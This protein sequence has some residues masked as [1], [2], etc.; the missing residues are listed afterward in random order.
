M[1]PIRQLAILIATF[2]LLL[3]SIAPTL[4]Q[5]PVASDAN[6]YIGHQARLTTVLPSGWTYLPLPL[7][8]YG[9]DT[10]FVT[11]TV[12][13][14]DANSIFTE[15]CTSVLPGWSGS[16][17]TTWHGQPACQTD[18]TY[19]DRPARALVI[20]HPFPFT[21]NGTEITHVA[22][23]TDPEHFAEITES[24]SFDPALVTPRAYLSSV[25]DIVEANAWFGQEVDWDRFRP[26]MLA[27]VDNSLPLESVQGYVGTIWEMLRSYGDNHSLVLY[28]SQSTALQE[29]R[30][31]G[32]IVGGTRIIAVFPSSPAGQAGLQVGDVILTVN[33]IA[34]IPLQ[35]V[36]PGAGWGPNG[37]SSESTIT[38]ER[39]GEAT[40]IGV[41]L[42][43]TTYELYRPPV[44]HGLG[45]DL[46]YIE[47]PG[48]R[49]PGREVEFSQT[50]IDLLTT[51]D[52]QQPTCGWV[53]DLRMNFGGGYPPMVSAISPLVGN[54]VFVG[55]LHRSGDFDW[56][57]M[58][59]G[60]ITG[61][62]RTVSSYVPN[63]GPSL[64]SQPNLPIAV[65]T[66]GQTGS[67]GEVTTLAF[68]GNP[69]ARSFGEITSGLTTGNSLI[70][71]FDGTTF[72]LAEVAMVDRNGETHLEGI[73]P[74]E[75]V[76]I[77]WSTYGTAEDP[78]MIAAQEWLLTQPACAGR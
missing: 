33:G 58:E 25:L 39:S 18:G 47:I 63:T 73:R 35:G 51:I 43:T 78:V 36:D 19:A 1:R 12:I 44:G 48:Y 55:W 38:V 53:V 6:L 57:E 26:M 11:S 3:A 62:G 23:I 30:G 21:L 65:L 66:S 59:N 75:P 8:G 54:G 74:D 29:S 28:P 41:T 14:I 2:A 46:G 50:G 32:M 13:T 60:T 68:V 7:N 45:T 9:D 70:S 56:I 76:N 67:S 37:W 77:N 20:P 27:S 15:A 5:T 49:I 61:E 71:L 52:Q 72:I 4:A 17:V 10:G 42:T 40:P 34:P 69:S 24:I 64:L 16:S 31:F 22:V